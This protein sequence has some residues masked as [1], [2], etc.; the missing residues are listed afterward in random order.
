VR[1]GFEVTFE[2]SDP[3]CVDRPLTQGTVTVDVE[4]RTDPQDD[5]S[6]AGVIF[7]VQ[8]ATGDDFAF[9][10]TAGGYALYRRDAEG[11]RSLTSEAGDAVAPAATG[12]SAVCDRS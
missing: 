5:V 7:D 11:F 6:G 2:G 3:V 4:V 10:A 9:V 12:Y 8:E 1:S